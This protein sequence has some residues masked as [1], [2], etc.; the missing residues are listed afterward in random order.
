[1]LTALVVGLVL[2]VAGVP[3]VADLGR[4]VQP[5]I[6]AKG[7]AGHQRDGVQVESG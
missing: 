5:M 4:R 2:I 1:L 3:V 7:E 6:V